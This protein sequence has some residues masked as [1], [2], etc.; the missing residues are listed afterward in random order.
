M[1]RLPVVVA[2]VLLALAAL[3]LAAPHAVRAY[4]EW[5]A[6]NPVRRGLAIAERSGCFSCHGPMGTRGVGDPGPHG[7][8]VPEWID[9]AWAAYVDDAAG[10]REYVLRGSAL[11]RE[12]PVAAKPSRSRGAIEMPAYAGRL[13]DEEVRDVVAAFLVVSGMSRPPAGTPAARGHAYAHERGCFAC[14]GPGGSGGL[15]NPGSMAG[16]VPGWYGAD[17]RDLVADRGEF[18]TWI[19]EGRSARIEASALGRGF[20]ARQAI[21]MPAYGEVD[22]DDLEGLWAYVSWLGDTGGGVGPE[23]EGL[24]RQP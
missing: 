5:R 6:S 1:K 18:E 9:G 22:P 23:L 16:F 21:R 8:S 12:T 3:V 7:G 19:R 15:S 14:H 11:R 20:L 2:I 24:R 10:V 4:W 17:F 13:S